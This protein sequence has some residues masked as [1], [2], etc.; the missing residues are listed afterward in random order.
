MKTRAS[1]LPPMSLATVTELQDSV[2]MEAVEAETTAAAEEAEA[3]V[4]AAA[5]VEEAVAGAKPYRASK[6]RAFH[7]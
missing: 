3:T 2:G 5:M 6:M 1:G 7:T 4:V